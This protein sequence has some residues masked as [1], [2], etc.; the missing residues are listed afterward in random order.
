MPHAN[1][2]KKV[3]WE[4]IELC[5]ILGVTRIFSL[6]DGSFKGEWVVTCSTDLSD[7]RRQT[8]VEVFVM[9]NNQFPLF[10][11]NQARNSC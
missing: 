1:V 7:K 4:V 11:K 5:V 9:S 10:T 8:P 6:A 3:L 2:L